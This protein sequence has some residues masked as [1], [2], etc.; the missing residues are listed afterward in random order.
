MKTTKIFHDKRYDPQK[1]TLV[2]MVIWQLSQPVIGS[3]HPF[4]YR[5]FYGKSGYRI[6]GYDNERGKGDHKH[7]N[8]REIPYI[9]STPEQLILDFLDDTNKWRPPM[10]NELQIHIGS[11]QEMGQRFV[12]AWKRTE[13]GES[14]N[15]THLTF[16][17]LESLLMTLTPKRFELLRL[18]KHQGVFS[19]KDL[20]RRLDR[21]YKNIYLDAKALEQAGLLVK[22][23]RKMKMPWSKVQ[24]CIS[25]S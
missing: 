18:A 2:E 10:N 21:D 7:F 15:E 11:I 4:K 19:I 22:E 8:E 9:F 1:G 12:S 3:L 14:I 23:G 17:D 5:L 13:G 20:S 24:A 6:V 16:P 25:F